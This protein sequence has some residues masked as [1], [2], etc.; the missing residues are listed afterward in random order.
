MRISICQRYRWLALIARALPPVNEPKLAPRSGYRWLVLIAWCLLG[1]V[2]CAAIRPVPEYLPS[3]VAAELLASL[4]ARA[5]YWQGYQAQAALRIQ[6][7]SGNYRLQAF[8]VARPPDRL[9]IEATNPGGQTVWVLILNPEDAMFWLPGEG[10]IYQ[11]KRGDTIINHFAG[12]PIPADV[13][14]YCFVGAIP[15]DHLKGNKLRLAPK[16]DKIIGQYW[17]SS[18]QW[19]FTWGLLSHPAALQSLSAMPGHAIDIED[20]QSEQHYSIRFE[21]PVEVQAE[22]KPQKVIITAKHWQLEGTLKQLVKLDDVPLNAFDH[23]SVPGAK[24][25]NLDSH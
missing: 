10:V 23:L 9:R 12:A 5:T 16:G 6:S 4:Q 17:D 24:V 15:P 11:A 2:A 19:R 8:L 18:K 25:I 1:T 13:F 20:S 14:A 21:P 7:P 22:D 3:P